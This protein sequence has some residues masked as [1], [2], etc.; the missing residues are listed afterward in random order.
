AVSGVAL[1][2]RTIVGSACRAGAIDS[3]EIA[4][5]AGFGTG[6][7]AA[8]GDPGQSPIRSAFTCQR[9]IR[10]RLRKLPDSTT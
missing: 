5:E 1:V 2:S 8:H 10:P 4:E 6:A 9:L 7:G 3:G